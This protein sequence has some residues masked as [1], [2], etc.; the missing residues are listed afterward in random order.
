MIN[1]A[2]N[3]TFFITLMAYSHM[4][5]YKFPISKQLYS[6]LSWVLWFF[7]ELFEYSMD[8]IFDLEMV[9]VQQVL[10]SSY[11]VLIQIQLQI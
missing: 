11:G 10:E 3:H 5:R 4:K 1:I 9:G 8:F 6:L 7:F 2:H